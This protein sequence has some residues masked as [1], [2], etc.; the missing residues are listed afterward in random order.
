MEESEYFK[1]GNDAIRES[2]RYFEDLLITKNS[3]YNGSVFKSIE[4]NF[5]LENDKFNSL[6][7]KEKIIFALIVRINDKLRRIKN[8]NKNEDEDIIEDLTGYLI[9]LKAVKSFSKNISL[10]DNNDDVLILKKD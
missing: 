10:E 9:L 6:S 7:D 3:K 1:I 8:N 2:V 4:Y 5:D